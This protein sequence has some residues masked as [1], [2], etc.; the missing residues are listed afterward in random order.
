MRVIGSIL[1]L[2]ALI[3]AASP[4]DAATLSRSVNLKA[5]P[6]TVWALIGPFC[7]VKEWHPYVKSCTL[8]GKTPPTRTIT[9]K[10]GNKA[11]IERETTRS[12]ANRFYAYTILSS[13]MP[14]SHY[15]ATLQVE[16]NGA[17]KSIVTW[18]AA[19]EPLKG[20][21]KAAKAEV[22]G[23]FKSGLSALKKR[24]RR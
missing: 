17:G 2:F 22:N 10:T 24:Y 9:I 21:E 19:Y 6:E 20:K 23:V 13:P 16:G 8:D 7:A 1:A 14:V 3:A 11:F 18:S 15:S 5:S 4:A 12:D